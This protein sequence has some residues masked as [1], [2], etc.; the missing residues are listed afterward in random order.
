MVHISC[1]LHC[2][3]GLSVARSLHLILQD[4]ETCQGNSRFCHYDWE[5]RGLH[6]VW[7]LG[8]AQSSCV[9]LGSWVSTW[10]VATPG[11]Q[12]CLEIRAVLR[13]TCLLVVL[14]VNGLCGCWGWG[15]G[16]G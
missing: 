8:F 6:S 5:L 11:T 13:I 10:A 15:E 4:L 16:L 1:G 2:R 14:V 3:C 12:C 9:Q 7:L